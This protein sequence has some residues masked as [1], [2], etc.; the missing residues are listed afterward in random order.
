MC[1]VC[2]ARALSWCVSVSVCVCVCVCVC[3]SVS[4][5]VVC[6]C[7][8]SAVLCHVTP[9]MWRNAPDP[10]TAISLS[11]VGSSVKDYMQTLERLGSF[12]AAHG[13]CPRHAFAGGGR[14]RVLTGH[15][16]VCAAGSAGGGGGGDVDVIDL[17]APAGGAGAGAG[18]AASAGAAAATDGSGAGGGS[19]IDVDMAAPAV[20]DASGSGPVGA[21]SGRCC[22]MI[23]Y[24]CLCAFVRVECVLV[25]VG[26]LVCKC[27][28]VV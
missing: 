21:A 9:I 12:I 8:Y 11:A 5:R 1:S 3:V 4:V 22:S 14:Q 26:G 17:D 27:M 6:V 24:L 10:F 13:V 15:W 7:V 28:C 19:C 23:A 18:G 25:S 16:R 2:A 20:A